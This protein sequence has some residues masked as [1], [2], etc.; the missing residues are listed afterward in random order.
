MSKRLKKCIDEYPHKFFFVHSTFMKSLPKIFETGEL[1]PGV[2]AQENIK[3]SKLSQIFFMINFV[4]LKTEFDFGP[5]IL[6]KPELIC[7]RDILFN[8]D[9]NYGGEDTDSIHIHKT[10]TK[11]DLFDKL[12][13]IYEHVKQRT[14]YFCHEFVVDEPIPIKKYGLG[15]VLLEYEKYIDNEKDTITYI[16]HDNLIK[17]LK[18]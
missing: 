11:K 9:W 3:K 12:D 15:V 7:D 6:F 17:K 13:K 5:Y 8:T 1:R 16:R 4:D 10:D 14:C 18:K 2:D